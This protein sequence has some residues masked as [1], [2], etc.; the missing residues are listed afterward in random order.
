ML[1]G[2][3]THE[4]RVVTMKLYIT[5]RHNKV[6]W[7]PFYIYIYLVSNTT[8]W[9]YTLMNIG[10]YK[11]FPQENTI[12]S[13]LLPYICSAQRCHYNARFKPDILYV[14]GHPYNTPPPEAPTPKFPIQFMKFL[15]YDRFVK[16]SLA[17]KTTK[18]QI[19][20]QQHN[21]KRMESSPTLG[22]S[23]WQKS[24]HTHPINK[25]TRNLIKN[26]G[27]QNQKSVQAN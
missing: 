18:Y 11:G 12:P 3:F 25:K 5:K 22:N 16:E 2:H 23:C 27:H 13:W 6:V 1:K 19:A 26:L 20:H 10:T 9:N 15:Y 4:P 17:M 8:S 24:N 14:V 7:E 21:Y